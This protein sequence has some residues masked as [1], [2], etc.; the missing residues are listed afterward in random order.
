[1]ALFSSRRTVFN[2]LLSNAEKLLISSSQRQ[3]SNSTGREEAVVVTDDGNT[4]VCW[5]PEPKVPYH[6]TKPLP[7][8]AEESDS[9]LKVQNK[10]ELKQLFSQQHPFFINKELRELTFTTKHPWYPRPGKRFAKK[11]PPR[12][13]EYL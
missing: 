7:E 1:M 4:I 10:K 13:R 12:D 3:M 6:L 2:A 9:I 11:Q 5:H 8:T